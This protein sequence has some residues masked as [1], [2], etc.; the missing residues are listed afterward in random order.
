MKYI[1]NEALRSCLF[2]VL[3]LFVGLIPVIGDNVL[4]LCS[5]HICWEEKASS[6]IR[7]SLTD[8][9]EAL[10]LRGK[11]RWLSIRIGWLP[12]ILAFIPF[13]RL[14]VSAFI[15]D[16]RGDRFGFFG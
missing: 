8:P 12:T 4:F 1:F 16:L 14:A 13:Y 3:L 2:P 5:N 11:W 15:T 9:D 6:L 10:E 7:T